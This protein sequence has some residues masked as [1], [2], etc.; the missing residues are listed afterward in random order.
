M[1]AATPLKKASSTFTRRSIS[2]LIHLHNVAQWPENIKESFEKNV[3]VVGEFISDREEAGLISEV[4]PHMKRLRYEKSH[5]DD[6]IHLYREREQRK[7]SD[8]NEMVIQRVR[9]ASFPNLTRHLTYVHILDLHKDGVIKAHIDS[10]RYCGDVV[11]GISLLSN[12][13]MRLRHK[14]CKDLI[15]DLYLARRSLY[16]LSNI[17][18]YDFTHEILGESNS[19]FMGVKIISMAEPPPPYTTYS[20]DS[21]PR[22][23]TTFSPHMASPYGTGPSAPPPEHHYAQI[24][25]PHYSRQMPVSEPITYNQRLPPMHSAQPQPMPIHSQQQPVYNVTQILHIKFGPKP[26]E[27]V[28]PFCHTHTR[29]RIKHESGVLSWLLCGALFF[30][31]FWICCCCPFC[32]DA[33]M[34]VDHF[35][36][37]YLNERQRAKMTVPLISPGVEAGFQCADCSADGPTWA[38]LN[39]GVLVCNECCFVHR[40]LG[41]HVSQIRSIKKGIWEQAQLELVYT[42]HQAGANRVWEHALLDPS[43]VS[44]GRRKPTQYDPVFP[45]KEAFIKAKYVEHAFAVRPSKDD[46]PLDVDDLNRQL[47]SCVRTGHV[48]TT[49]RLLA[50]GA[51]PNYADPER[52]NTPLHIAAKEGQTLQ[53]ELLY[54]YGADP[55]QINH[56]EMTPAQVAKA[57]GFVDLSNRLTELCFEVTNRLSIFLC[58]R[59]PDHQKGHHFLIPELTG[60]SAFVSLKTFRRQLQAVNANMFEKISQDVYDEVDRRETVAAWSASTKGEVNLGNENVVAVFLPLNPALSATRNQ[61]RQKLAKYD[62]REFAALVIDV[63]KEAKR[64]YSG[65][66]PEPEEDEIADT[67]HNQATISSPSVHGF[68][69][70]FRDYDDVADCSALARNAKRDSGKKMRSSSQGD[71]NL[72]DEVLELRERVADVESKISTITSNNSQILKLV[73]GL[74]NTIEKLHGENMAMRQEMSRLSDAQQQLSLQKRL[75]SPMTHSQPPTTSLFHQNGSNLQ[76]S[77]IERASSMPK[78]TLS[79]LDDPARRIP[80]TQ[81]GSTPTGRRSAD[82]QRETER[83]IEIERLRGESREKELLRERLERDRERGDHFSNKEYARDHAARIQDIFQD[84]VFPDNIVIETERLTQLIRVVLKDAQQ[85]DLQPKAPT[86]AHKICTQVNQMLAMVPTGIPAADEASTAMTDATMVLAAKC[87]SPNFNSEAT[88][89]AAYGLAKAAKTLLQVFTPMT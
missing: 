78:Q 49:L 44:K 28:C 47:W 34:D 70:G 1:A 6:A 10:I 39:R 12:T 51:D 72:R 8:A 71:S 18:R 4:E 79:D 54:L 29:S 88:C 24:S 75:P 52:Q 43:Y 27:V 7:W 37:Q 77:L 55:A 33:C 53:V 15:A 83:R 82:H 13:V 50:M 5:W 59:K 20:S 89:Q 22:L 45:M 23:E 63:L 57:E 38:S 16:K 25:Q 9:E 56:G 30:F 64:R 85:G 48:D 74:Q 62:T 60:K 26:C 14:D 2:S 42:L 3:T 84:S 17:G 73:S 35:C 80:R 36:S 19:E 21:K 81:K 40:N 65:E 41:R 61:M 87:N 67:S 66:P 86:H 76:Q 58:G 68:S 32:I 31:G 46:A 69:D 11:T